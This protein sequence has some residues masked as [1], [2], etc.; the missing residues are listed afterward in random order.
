MAI[1]SN[2]ATLRTS[3]ANWLNRSDFSNDQLDQFIEMGE[4]MIYET[5][6]VPPLERKATFSIA[7]TD[8]SINIP[9]GYLE[10][11]ELRKLNKGECSVNAS[12][13]TT[14]ELCVADGGLWTDSD[15]QDDIVLDRVDAKALHNNNLP[16]SFSRELDT[17]LITDE[18]GKQLASG[19]YN[20]KYYYAEPPIGTIISGV[21]VDPYILQEYELI[22]YGALAFGFAFLHDDEAATK[23]STL[24][25]AKIKTLNEKAK[26]AERKSGQYTQSFKSNLI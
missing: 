13:N 17:F 9:T 23:Y 15:K 3:V 22:L 1:I 5:L 25:E 4:A 11:I 14:R 12:V 2:Q 18:D 20:L 16:N 6:R 7:S 24:V 19:E 8:S 26:A 21:E 10:V